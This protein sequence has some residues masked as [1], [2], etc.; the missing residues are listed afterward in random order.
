MPA[1]ADSLSPMPCGRPDL[2]YRGPQKDDDK[3]RIN[4][5][6]RPQTWCNSAYS[7]SSSTCYR[8]LVC[9]KQERVGLMSSGHDWKN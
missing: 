4:T 8:R 1:V 7:R 6:R 9:A 5:R 3:P 2:R